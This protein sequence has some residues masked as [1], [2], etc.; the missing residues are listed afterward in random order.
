MN[1]FRNTSKPAFDEL[2]L[3][4]L[5]YTCL[6][7][8]SVSTY[9]MVK[10]GSLSSDGSQ[11]A[12]LVPIIIIAI[13]IALSFYHAFSK[14]EKS[15]IEKQ[16]MYLFASFVSGFAGIWGGSYLLSH[17]ENGSWTLVFPII[18]IIVGWRMIGDK[19]RVLQDDCIDDRDA[20]LAEVAVSA[21]IV[22][23]TFLITTMYF[24]CHWAATMSIC[25]AYG[26]SLNRIIVNILLPMK[27]G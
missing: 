22:T 20:T 9:D 24:H 7:L 23:A 11:N 27:Q 17:T 4:V 8:I 19:E 3:F 15:R 1:F 25:A 16:I 10:Q 26:T 2:T 21:A 18:N 6:L 12:A 13:G 14:R 5:A